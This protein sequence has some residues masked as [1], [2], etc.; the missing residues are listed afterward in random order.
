[1]KPV[2]LALLALLSACAA[3]ETEA[4]PAPQP[5]GLTQDERMAWWREARFGMF[6]HWG[7]YAL[8]AGAWDDATHHGEWIRDTAQ[9]ELPRY[10]EL[11][12]RFE[13]PDFDADVWARAAAEAGMQ[14]L[15]ITSKHHDGFA[16][17][18]S[19]LSDWDVAATPC[20]RD[21]LRELADA[22]ARHGLRFGTYHSIMDWHHPDY[23]PRRPWETRSAAGADFAR[24]E[25]YLHGQVRE[26][27]ERYHPA[28]M[29]FDGE[30]ESTWN[31]ERGVRL[32]ELCRALDPALIVNNRVDVHR[33]GMGGFA[34][35]PDARGD[36]Q[37]PE[38]EVPAS[39]VAGVDWETCMTMNGHWGWNQA[40]R[41]W[42]PSTELIRTLVDIASK[43]GNF[44]LNVGPTAEGRFPPE[45]L[46]RLADLG[47]WMDVHAEAI[48]GT[49]AS[50]F[51]PLE[52]GRVTRKGSALYLH[53][54]DWP[55][56]GRLVLPGLATGALRAHLLGDPARAVACEPAG[57]G[58]VVRVAG[59]APGHAC[60]VVRVELAG[61]PE[62]HQAPRIEAVADLF[63]ERAELRLVG[64]VRG[65][66]L[67]YTTD[68]SDPTAA[69][70]LYRGGFVIRESCTVRARSFA[71]E[72][73]LSPL[74]ERTFTRAEPG[75]AFVPVHRAA[76]LLCERFPG[77][78]E[79]LPDF[80]ALPSG[81][82]VPVAALAL[83]A[84]PAAEFVARRYTGF[85]E[86]PEDGIWRFA[87]TSDDGSRLFIDDELVVDNDGLHGPE[88]R[89]GDVALA[90]GAHHLRVE[91][92]NRTGGAQLELR[93]GRVEGALKPLDPRWLGFTATE[94]PAEAPGERAR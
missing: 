50:P 2:L 92:F 73:A 32:F 58:L 54:F 69:S 34:T 6:I 79:A 78:F 61:A 82:R 11:L 87:L 15:V 17:Y 55:A 47:R 38:Q 39:A 26:L 45:A 28:V 51:G 57:D 42:K 7:L 36:Y 75:P 63:L 71:G 40:D 46:E 80:D 86:L 21:I 70:T 4:A 27:V 67:R 56:D 84:T 9:I 12:G 30:W 24:F 64:S 31:H 44:L 19:A 29:W 91:W 22:C 72:R 52:F 5:P 60:P 62:V 16:L 25:R 3:P 20:R 89:Q 1:M 77:R 74:A 35:H 94:V 13:A 66:P 43:G 10:A 49:Q 85:V 76:G 23:L 37:T 90:R 18:D 41:D 48:R 14:Y 33:A 8:P 88:E 68:G 81:T 59:A 53:V 65:A 93:L 83:P